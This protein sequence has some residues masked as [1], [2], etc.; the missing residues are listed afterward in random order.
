MPLL[1][2]LKPG[3]KVIINGAVIENAGSSTK[4]RILNNSGILRQKEIL[5]DVDAVTPASR[6]YY[7]LQCAY[8]FPDD[9]D[10]YLKAFAQY[11]ADYI[12]ACP[13]ASGIAEEIRGE[14]A[15]GRYYKG[16]KAARNLLK[17]ESKVVAQ[18]QASV[19]GAPKAT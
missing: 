11:L 10:N 16:L 1:I 9:R 12:G 19:Q 7:A 13:S 5:S 18:F 3:E 8:L 2:D 15:E 17:H 4:L 6:V 14:L